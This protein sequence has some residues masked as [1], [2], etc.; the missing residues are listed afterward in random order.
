MLVNSGL[1]IICLE[2]AILI[3]WISCYGIKKQKKEIRDK[4][5]FN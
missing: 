2:L 3:G 1:A 4:I 5:D